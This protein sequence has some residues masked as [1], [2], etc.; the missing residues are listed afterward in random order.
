MTR[1]FS[2]FSSRDR[3]HFLPLIFLGPKCHTP[4][5]LLFLFPLSST[6][7]IQIIFPH[8]FGPR[9]MFTTRF[10][11]F[12]PILGRRNHSTSFS[13]TLLFLAELRLPRK[14]SARIKG[15]IG[16][17]ATSRDSIFSS[18]VPLS[19]I[20]ANKFSILQMNVRARVQSRELCTS[21]CNLSRIWGIARL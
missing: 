14:D 5:H 7:S 18:F 9:P 19:V 8:R 17:L 4:F 10:S 2:T 1:S 13:S 12:F 3:I 15:S 6:I 16:W 11:N 20:S 21:A